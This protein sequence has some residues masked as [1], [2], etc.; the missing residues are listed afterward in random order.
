MT[1]DEMYALL[2]SLIDP[3][4]KVD[5]N[6]VAV[7][8]P[9]I[10]VL[11]SDGMPRAVNIAAFAVVHDMLSPA[12][13]ERGPFQTLAM[14]WQTFADRPMPY[15]EGT[16]LSQFVVMVNGGFIFIEACFTSTEEDELIVER[17][18]VALKGWADRLMAVHL[19]SEMDKAMDEIRTLWA[20]EYRLNYVQGE[21]TLEVLGDEPEQ[22]V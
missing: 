5:E 7:L 6:N 22:N 2:S 3:M 18:S 12:K 20:S 13:A 14:L 1:R 19:L 15:R 16:A 17:F 9:E 4:I 8:N 21:V 11:G 10:T